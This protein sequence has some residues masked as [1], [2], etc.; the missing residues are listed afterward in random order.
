MPDSHVAVRAYSAIGT[1]WNV[2][3][4]GRTG[5]RYEAVNDHLERYRKQL[6]ITDPWETIQD[7]QTIEFAL[8]DAHDEIREEQREKRDQ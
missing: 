7:I 6:E 4:A 5:L 2:G 3:M 1:Q 8:L